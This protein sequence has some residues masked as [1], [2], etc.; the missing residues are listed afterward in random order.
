[1]AI[2]LNRQIFLVIS[3]VRVRRCVTVYETSYLFTSLSVTVIRIGPRVHRVTLIGPRVNAN[4]CNIVTRDG[5]E[6][7]WT[8]VVRYL[9][10]FIESALC[11]KCSLDNA[12]RSFD[13][14]FDGIFGR[15]G[16]IASNEV[17]EQLVKS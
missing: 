12:K 6:L 10:I 7:A 11:F 5:R 15:V 2:H 1:V 14:S 8:N 17:I 9:G 16:R 4:C 3:T 13:R